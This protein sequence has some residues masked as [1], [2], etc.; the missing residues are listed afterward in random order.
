MTDFTFIASPQEIATV[1]L[2]FVFFIVGAI[3]VFVLV[4]WVAELIENYG[5]GLDNWH[6]TEDDR[7]ER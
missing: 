4:E 2:V 1:G 5:D 6:I 3:A 7:H